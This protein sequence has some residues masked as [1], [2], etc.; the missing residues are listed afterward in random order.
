[1]INALSTRVTPVA[2]PLGI[3]SPPPNTLPSM[4]PTGTV[5]YVCLTYNPKRF[6]V[7]GNPLSFEISSDTSDH[8]TNHA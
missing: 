7:Q 1:M 2:L 3:L 8:I 6:R 5:A 4:L